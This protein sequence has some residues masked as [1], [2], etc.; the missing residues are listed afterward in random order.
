MCLRGTNDYPPVLAVMQG[1]SAVISEQGQ[2]AG[3]M[4][5]L[6]ERIVF[7]DKFRPI[8]A[9]G[10]NMVEEAARYLDGDGRLESRNLSRVASALYATE[11]M[12]L[13]SR[14]MQIASWLLLQRAMRNGE[15]SRQQVAAE[16]A[17][18]RLD[19]LSAGHEAQGWNELPASFV[20]LVERSLR[21]QERIRRMDCEVPSEQ[22]HKATDR[23]GNPV[24]QQIVLL[25]T[26]FGAA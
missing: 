16:K 1:G 26:A 12:R 22:R 25:R 7:S 14:L 17:K 21:L 18:V 24:S 8:Y 13:T 9:E 20:E 23:H 10:M 15:M 19:T 4:I 2:M 3:N 5:S 11:S 6:A